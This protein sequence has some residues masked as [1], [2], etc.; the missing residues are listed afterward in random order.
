MIASRRI[1][2]PALTPM[3]QTFRPA[4]RY[5]PHEEMDKLKKTLMMAEPN[6]HPVLFKLK[7]LWR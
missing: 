6:K 7:Y 5:L 2:L 1:P 3:L 4:F